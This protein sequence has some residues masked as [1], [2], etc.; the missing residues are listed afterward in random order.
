M[1]KKLD[2]TDLILKELTDIKNIMIAHDTAIKEHKDL[3]NYMIGLL[4]EIHPKVSD[5]S[6]K[7]DL[8]VCTLNITKTSKKSGGSATI[9]KK[10]K[11]NIQI[12]FKNKFKQNIESIKHIISD[13]EIN[14]I[15]AQNEKDIKKKKDADSQLSFKATL[16]YKAIKEDSEK[17]KK[18]K[19]M[20]EKEEQ[21]EESESIQELE[22]NNLEE[23]D[24]D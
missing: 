22:E 18:L 4:N 21:E 13:D 3:F 20:K 19:S 1:T 17:L 7:V 16:I 6:C 24:D 9:P 10:T 23:N 8:D 12:Y 11:P 14:S 5:L 15:F 2:K